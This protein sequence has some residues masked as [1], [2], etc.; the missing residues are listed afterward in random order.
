[1]WFRNTKTCVVE[2]RLTSIHHKYWL[3]HSTICLSSQIPGS[4]SVQLSGG[5][6]THFSRLNNSKGRNFQLRSKLKVIQNTCTWLG[7]WIFEK[8]RQ[9]SALCKIILLAILYYDTYNAYNAWGTGGDLHF[10]LYL[11]NHDWV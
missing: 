5:V 6:E 7:G 3:Q 8:I 4:S 9:I 11:L 10:S 2:V 1:M